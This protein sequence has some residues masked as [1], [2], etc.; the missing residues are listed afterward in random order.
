MSSWKEIY[1]LR[2]AIGKDQSES[3]VAERKRLSSEIRGMELA[4]AGFRKDV[5]N[6]APLK[7]P[8]SKTESELIGES[9]DATIKKGGI[10][11][12]G[13]SVA[14]VT[15]TPVIK[16]AL[17]AMS[18]VGYATANTADNYLDS[19]E[20][21]RDGNS[22]GI[23]DFLMAP[24]TGIGQGLNAGI[25]QNSEDSTTFAD[26][27]KHG[28]GMVGLDTENDA[29]KW[30]Q[31]IGGFAGDVLLDP[32]TYL[33]VGASALA[34]GA[35]RGARQGSKT[36]KEIAEQAITKEKEVAELSPIKGGM[37]YG[38][39][40]SNPK[41]R[42]GTAI[43]EA[44]RDHS[45]W[46]AARVQRR[47]DKKEQK[48]AVDGGNINEQV[49]I[50]IAAIEKARK[51]EDALKVAAQTNELEAQLEAEVASAAPK[52]AP[53]ILEEIKLDLTPEEVPEVKIEP[54]PVKAV[55]ET[56][57]KE[58][59]NTIAELPVAPVK[60]E[61]KSESYI[62]QQRGSKFDEL[63]SVF[64]RGKYGANVQKELASP[65][66]STIIR[67]VPD[68]SGATIRVPKV[69]G[70]NSTTAFTGRT[71]ESKDQAKARKATSSSKTHAR[72]KEEK[73]DWDNAPHLS[74]T[75]Y[76]VIIDD[77]G[78]PTALT[79]KN[80]HSP[81]NID[82]DVWDNFVAENGDMELSIRTSKGSSKM[83]LS[84][85]SS[86]MKSENTKVA[87]EYVRQ[88]LDKFVHLLDEYAD[89]EFKANID[90]NI[91]KHKA[92][93]E[94]HT[95]PKESADLANSLDEIIDDEADD[96]YPKM[97][98]VEEANPNAWSPERA[99]A[100]KIDP[101]D[102]VL[103]PAEISA[104]KIPMTNPQIIAAIKKGDLPKSTMDMLRALTGKVDAVEVGKEFVRMRKEYDKYLKDK[105]IPAKVSRDS[106]EAEVSRFLDGREI[107]KPIKP[108]DEAINDIQAEA[109]DL[110][111]EFVKSPV[112][113]DEAYQLEFRAMNFKEAVLSKKHGIPDEDLLKIANPD[114]GSVGQKAIAEFAHDAVKAALAVQ[115]KEAP[116]RTDSGMR[117]MTPDKTTGGAWSPKSWGSDSQQA[118]HDSIIRSMQTI[119]KNPDLKK[120]DFTKRR[121]Y[122]AALNIADKELRAAGVE[123][124]LN[125][126]DD[127]KGKART[128]VSLYD[129]FAAL[130]EGGQI[131]TL[132]YVMFRMPSTSLGLTPAQG[133]VETLLRMRKN[134]NSEAAI[135][136]R[137]RSVLTSSQ[138]HH[139]RPV[140]N[141]VYS[142]NNTANRLS[143]IIDHNSTLQEI[144][145]PK[146]LARAAKKIDAQTVNKFIDSLMDPTVYRSLT[147]R[148]LINQAAHNSS[149]GDFVEKYA[150]NMVDRLYK[151][152]EAA[153]VGTAMKLFVTEMAELKKLISPADYEKGKAALD[154][155]LA[156]TVSEVERINIGTTAQRVKVAEQTP[157]VH[158]VPAK[159]VAQ[160]EKI[161]QAVNKTHVEDAK[162]VEKE[163]AETPKPDDVE[164][165]QIKAAEIAT[166]AAKKMHP[167]QR[168]T[169]PS[170]GLSTDVYRAVNSGLH[171]IAR[172]QAHFHQSLSMHLEKYSAA[173]LRSDFEELQVMARNTTKGDPFT[174]PADM[175][176]SMREM[177]GIVGTM[178]EVSNR[179]VFARNVVGAKHFND[180]ARSQGLPKEWEFDGALS[181]YDN[182]HL[183]ATKWE[184][185]G[186][187]GI[188]DFLSKMHSVSVKAS[189]EIAIAASFSKDFGKKVREEGYVKLH[190]DNRRKADMDSSFYDLIDQDLYYPKDIAAQVI[191]VHNLMRESRSLNTSKPLGKFFVNVFDPVTNAL[192]ASQTTVRPGHWVI[193]VAGDLLRNQLA[194]VNSIQP[195]RHALRIMRANGI[196][197]SDFMD[198]IAS[199]GSIASYRK[200]QESAGAFMANGEGDGMH[201]FIGGKKMKVSYET[202]EKILHD[203][204]MLPKHRG[205][206][207]VIE[208]RFVGENV[209]NQLSRKLEKATDFVTDNDKF[210]LNALA[211]K[212][213]NFMRISLAVDFASKRKWANV[214]EMKKG[215]EEYVTKWAPTST[216]MTAFESK[217]M[218]RSMLYYTWLRGITPR[219]ID[220]AMTKPGITTMVPKALYNVAYANGLN[221]ESIGNPFPEDDGLFPSYYYNNVLGPQW[222][223]DYGMW[224]I[225]PSSPV[226]EVANT[227][228]NFKL[229]D[230]VGNALGAGA[231]LTGM[232]TPFAKMP[233]EMAFGQQ[234]SG[235]PIED[236]AQYL[237]DN[238]GG[239]YVGALSRATGKTVNMN[240]IV[241]RTDSAA[242]GTPEEQAEHA[243]LQG[244]NFMTG[245]KLTDY[246]SDSAIKAANYDIV[247][248]M[249]QQVEAQRRGQ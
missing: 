90:E 75:K 112:A 169:N 48:N 174:I 30:T 39:I 177:Y 150:D 36:A 161:Q 173:Q 144:G 224:G 178:F 154:L 61:P 175:S 195:Y 49:G 18:T 149:L 118:L 192:K 46:K 168:F 198:K 156:E 124:F 167:I 188:L 21:I 160:T 17:N 22:R 159:A 83:P 248:K 38:E 65:G 219:I 116:F 240:G 201:F 113:F 6:S 128:N 209:T 66:E 121:F 110:A 210:S 98:D 176:Q 196:D 47:L 155:K 241:D 78:N 145:D 164:P 76:S 165:M 25:A 69:K 33:T 236:N 122:M 170:L 138:A 215:M 211:A 233:I 132:D 111:E 77:D 68:P 2:A 106:K 229:G 104:I 183:W 225:N 217:Y 9:L 97:I 103:T 31:G 148:Q 218:R 96:I 27:I 242:K 107:V 237:A 185:I 16:Q 208:D 4:K 151:L 63:A 88:N 152:S 157:V 94:A 213:D 12:F 10:E 84:G 194:G 99:I 126:V 220:S 73:V 13:A 238:L 191:Q 32:T 115:L 35:V 129:M 79:S 67:Q 56:F 205:G 62:Q 146:L 172:Q 184:G 60:V 137:L 235:I 130:D 212:R 72:L 41:G 28:Q 26:V 227:F 193:S 244:I 70:V 19:F 34:K 140:S 29:A 92:D 228:K 231:Q 74:D 105:A 147:Y 1:K 230:P 7:Q 64:Q 37:N 100:L 53:E 143:R 133:A 8:D 14:K 5:K 109:T 206:G 86:L 171:S 181:P 80:I 243:K 93:Y 186:E 45:S 81:G 153:G 123:P 120:M 44:S 222:K 234:S 24:V 119:F 203:V 232:A 87:D 57:T 166:A 101:N 180:L 3:N 91:A 142:L 127:I 158:T 82:E 249:K 59:E 199:A 58:V 23:T 89:P 55:P 239:S 114:T 117:T 223:D 131:N 134:N 139:G 214:N 221:P 95:T 200:G 163:I 51:E 15:E 42:I 71:A 197:T 11:G 102:A 207:G 179:N 245:A 43:Q 136:T 246:K 187:K 125:H 141:D 135:R 108:T 204:V 40:A 20:N 189:Q 54:T 216:D 190:W 85:L 162:A 247:D 226:I 52:T 50:D 202:M 182:S